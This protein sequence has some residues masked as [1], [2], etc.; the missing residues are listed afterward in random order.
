MAQI[1]AVSLEAVPKPRTIPQKISPDDCL[2][3]LLHSNLVALE[4]FFLLI[5]GK[6]QYTND[7]SISFGDSKAA[8]S[9]PATMRALEPHLRQIAMAHH[10]CVRST[11]H[12]PS[13]SAVYAA[14]RTVAEDLPRGSCNADAVCVLTP[15]RPVDTV[16]IVIEPLGS[17]MSIPMARVPTMVGRQDDIQR[18]LAWL[19]EEESA[20]RILIHGIPGVGKD[21]MT[22]AVV[23]DSRVYGNPTNFVRTY[24]TPGK[25]TRQML[26]R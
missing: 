11:R 24:G 1:R 25:H 13:L 19:V 5:M 26:H 9:D 10:H 16:N 18:V 12:R 21:V 22:A 2:S 4:E 20:P 17:R 6:F 8:L 23:Y 14:M 3:K 15:L 7:G